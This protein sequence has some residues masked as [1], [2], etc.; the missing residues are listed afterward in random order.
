M[1]KLTNI[2]GNFFLVRTI[3]E[4]VDNFINIYV[5]PCWVGTP[6]HAH[7]ILFI[8]IL[9]CWYSSR[10]SKTPFIALTPHV[11]C[12]HIILCLQLSRNLYFFSC[13]Y[14][15]HRHYAERHYAE[16]HYV[17][18]QYAERHIAEQH[19]AECDILPNATLCRTT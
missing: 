8:L 19:K 3:S 17:E 5:N 12:T 2:Y 16:R 18:R 13:S 9:F 4:H 6:Y 10:Y 14:A 15:I 11:Y 7:T 1:S